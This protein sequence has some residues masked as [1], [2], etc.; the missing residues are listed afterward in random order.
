ML[1]ALYK[2]NAQLSIT[3]RIKPC[4]MPWHG[5]PYHDDITDALE[6]ASFEFDCGSQDNGMIFWDDYMV[7]H[8]K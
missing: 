8:T 1:Q 7:I 5:M 2:G 4:G 3:E 6:E